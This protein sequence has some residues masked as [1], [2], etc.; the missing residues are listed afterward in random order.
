LFAGTPEA[1]RADAERNRTYLQSVLQSNVIEH[2]S[3]PFGEVSLTAKRTL[4]EDYRS[5]RSIYPGVNRGRVD[6]GLLRA[7][8]IYSATFEQA[9]FERL[10]EL[11]VRSHGWLILYTHGVCESP[12]KWSCTPRTV[13]LTVDHCL[14]AGMTPMSVS[15]VCREIALYR[16]G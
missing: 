14:R 3:F 4:L 10:V 5:L 2:F 8:S 16:K 7:N 9:R 11:A 15:D 12:D 6:L 13:R 1:L